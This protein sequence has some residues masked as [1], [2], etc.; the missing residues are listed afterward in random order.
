MLYNMTLY[1]GS[2]PIM[3]AL[4]PPLCLM[5]FQLLKEKSHERKRA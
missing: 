3:A 1:F 4:L 2:F 5:I